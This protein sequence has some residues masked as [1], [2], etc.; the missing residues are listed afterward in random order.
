MKNP[1]SPA[2]LAT[3]FLAFAL[4]GIQAADAVKSKS[5][6][7]TRS[8]ISNNKGVSDPKDD[9]CDGRSDAPDCKK[10]ANKDYTTDPYVETTQRDQ[11]SGLSTGKHT[12]AATL[13]ADKSLN[14]GTGTIKGG[15]RS[16]PSDAPLT[17]D[18][19]LPK[20]QKNAEFA[21]VDVDKEISRPSNSST[22][23]SGDSSGGASSTVEKFNHR[24]DF[25]QVKA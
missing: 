11:N 15:D 21:Q 17:M 14:S 4:T 23:S 9:D 10:T 2:I 24:Q 19:K 25:G 7:V 3:L 8:N 20:Q 6:P 18:V 1:F 16:R 12:T 22:N 5:T 13:K